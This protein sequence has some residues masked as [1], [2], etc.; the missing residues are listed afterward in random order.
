MGVVVDVLA[1]WDRLR[2]LRNTV[3]LSSRVR[4]LERRMKAVEHFVRRYVEPHRCLCCGAWSLRPD[5][6]DGR[7]ALTGVLAGEVWNCDH[8]GHEEIRFRSAY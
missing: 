7:G 3:N 8:C 4:Q 6:T 2:P 5:T 1:V